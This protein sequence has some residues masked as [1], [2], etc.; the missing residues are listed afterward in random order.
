[1]LNYFLS[2]LDYLDFIKGLFFMFF[3]GACLLYHAKERLNPFLFPLALYALFQALLS[4]SHHLVHVFVVNDSDVHYY[5]HAAQLLSYISLLVVWPSFLLRG[6][7]AA[8]AYTWLS[9]LGFG[10]LLVV[11]G[12]SHAFEIFSLL[13]MVLAT[14]LSIVAIFRYREHSG[15]RAPS[16]IS[17]SL[18][19]A[20]TALLQSGYG[21][22]AVGTLVGVEHVGALIAL[23]HTFVVIVAATVVWLDIILFTEEGEADFLPA[24]LVARG[25]RIR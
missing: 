25:H 9:M 5:A 17:I 24:R 10:G 21:S 23:I 18:L 11:F 20:A 19:I 15:I 8:T 14:V 4:W 13:I 2:Q 22:I 7:K 1:M 3:G 6:R 12:H 16:Y